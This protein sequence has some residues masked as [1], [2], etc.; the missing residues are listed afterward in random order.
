MQRRLLA[1]GFAL[2]FNSNAE[3]HG[4]TGL[5]A[6]WNPAASPLVNAISLLPPVTHASRVETAIFS[7]SFGVRQ[8]EVCP[9]P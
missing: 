6:G 5:E 1:I 9:G 4:L 3:E 2:S 7:E 8:D